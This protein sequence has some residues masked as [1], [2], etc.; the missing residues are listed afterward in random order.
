M[1]RPRD[2]IAALEHAVALAEA[3]WVGPFDLARAR[4][5]LGEA[6]RRAGKR[7]D[8]RH[9]LAQAHASFEQ[10]GAAPW[11][12][13]AAAELAA[14][15]ITAARRRSPVH[16]RLTPQELRVAL[17]VA[18]GYSNQEVAARLFLSPKTIEV[19]L[20][21]IYAK[22]GLRSRTALAREIS[23]GTISGQR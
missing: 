3:G 12:K 1:F 21:H 13:R 5:C 10:L 22:L 7:S 6:L 18:E 8:A 15:G 23:S 14:T 9:P 19:H 2:A 20:S 16:V 17:Q 4:L 11:A